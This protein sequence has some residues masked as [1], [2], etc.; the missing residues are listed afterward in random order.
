MHRT[1]YHERRNYC[2][3]RNPNFNGLTSLSGNLQQCFVE[4]Y[5][6]PLLLHTK[7]NRNLA[8]LVD[9]MLFL[10]QADVIREKWKLRTVC[11]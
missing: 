5:K 6:I 1:S 8:F 2:K 11:N 9:L 3:K 10:V 4:I 7:L